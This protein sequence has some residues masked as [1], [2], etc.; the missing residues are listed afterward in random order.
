MKRI[1]YPLVIA[2]FAMIIVAG[3][4]FPAS[5]QGG[6]EPVVTTGSPIVEITK[7]CP[8]LRY[9]GRDAAFEIVVSNR[10]TAA[11]TNV[12]VTDSLPMGIEFISADNGGQR[13]GNN[14]VWRLGSLQAG[15]SVTLNVT[16]RCNQIATI[17]NVATVTYCAE[18]SAICEFPVRGIPAIL[19][20]CVDDPDPIEV[21][22]QLTYSI[23]V[24]NQGSQVGTNIVIECIIPPEQEF[25]RAAGPTDGT[26]SGRQVRF[27]P[28]AS[29]PAKAKAVYA[30][31][32]RGISAA[33]SRFRVNLTSDQISSPVMETES[34]HIYE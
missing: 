13:S 18:A 25:V 6:T 17:R 9:L 34:T 26:E 10:G 29:L 23:V 27:A 19:L 8:N 7:R 30:V 16:V 4:S 3:M 2:M 24:T 33:D 28:L 20:E 14:V 5:V 22:E 31:T 11:A 1:Q 15:Q 32:V 12:V 21:G